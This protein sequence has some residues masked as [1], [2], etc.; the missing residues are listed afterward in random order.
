MVDGVPF[1]AFRKTEDNFI[2]LFLPKGISEFVLEGTYNTPFGIYFP[3]QAS[4]LNFSSSTHQIEGLEKDHSHQKTLFFWT[5]EAPHIFS[6][7]SNVNINISISATQTI[8]QYQIEGHTGNQTYLLPEW[9]EQSTELE[10]QQSKELFPATE[11]FTWNEKI[12]TPKSLHFSPPNQQ[13][14][15]L[16]ITLDCMNTIL[17]TYEDQPFDSESPLAPLQSIHISPISPSPQKKTLTLLP[18]YHILS[19]TNRYERN[20]HT[21]NLWLANRIPNQ[22]W[23]HAHDH[24]PQTVFI[25]IG[26]SQITYL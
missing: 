13:Q 20:V 22:D 16:H 15:N 26:S 7:K 12:P 11:T 19:S 3:Q 4:R 9:Y 1:H 24:D 21:E 18:E 10:T 5:D 17:C 6:K 25:P 14:Y 8:F 23:D 2:A